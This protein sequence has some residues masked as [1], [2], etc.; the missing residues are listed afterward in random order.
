MKRQR[1]LMRCYKKLFED[2]SGFN[3]DKMSAIEVVW[4]ENKINVIWGQRQIAYWKQLR[5]DFLADFSDVYYQ[6][7]FQKVTKQKQE[8]KTA[9]FLVHHL[10]GW[11]KE[12]F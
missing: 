9:I 6:K 12:Y 5:L 8:D 4:R 1:A 10:S 2:A 11:V 7:V 3:L